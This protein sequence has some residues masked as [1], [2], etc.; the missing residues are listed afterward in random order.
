MTPPDPSDATPFDATP[1]DAA[2]FD[3]S[4]FDPTL[5]D[6]YMPSRRVPDADALVAAWARDSAAARQAFA[7]LELAYGA[8]EHERL[9]VFSPEGAARATLL[10]IHGGYW[11]AFYKASFSYLAPP[12]LAA[13]LRVAVI[14][15]DL[16]PAVTLGHIVGQARRATAFVAGQFAGPLVVAGHSAGGHLAAMIHATDWAAEGLPGVTL[17]GGIGISGLYDLRPLRR[18]ELQ[19]ALRLSPE[20]A[21]ALSPACL[22]PTSAAPFIAA[23]GADE[24][25]AFLGQSLTLARAWPGVVR[26]VRQLPGR[27]HFDAPDE[28]PALARALLGE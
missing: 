4:L 2:P 22:T 18:T 5:N 6:D 7:P 20:V 13:G 8:G 28:L 9:D 16:A 21:R 10:F 11:Q 26:G 25:G 23:V 27:H 17:A 24:S 19:P 14:S 3:T 1:S 15:Y 12:L